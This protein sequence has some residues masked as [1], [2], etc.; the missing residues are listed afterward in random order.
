MIRLSC[1]GSSL[2][3]A[4]G[5][6]ALVP[7]A[8]A[9]PVSINVGANTFVASQ[10]VF[11]TPAA[12]ILGRSFDNKTLSTV[13]TPLGTRGAVVLTCNNNSTLTATPPIGTTALATTFKSTATACRVF[14]TGASTNVDN[15]SC[16]A[17]ATVSIL[18]LS[19]L[20]GIDI[21]VTGPSA[22]PAGAYGF[23]TTLTATP[24]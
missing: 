10:C 11:G 20:L 5:V 3:A 23:R 24:L 17:N 7:S 19:N 13:G 15:I 22:A 21:G 6:V 18:P 12:G 14:V 1:L 16:T 9:A 4:A 8:H 2:I